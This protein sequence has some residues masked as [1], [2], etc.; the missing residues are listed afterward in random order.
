MP[1]VE[2]DICQ[3]TESVWEMMLGLPVVR[4][5]EAGPADARDDSITGCIQITGA[6]EVTVLMACSRELARKATARMFDKAAPDVEAEEIRDAVGKLTHMIGGGFKGLLPGLCFLS[7]PVVVEGN[8]YSIGLSGRGVASEV[9]FQCEGQPLRV[10]LLIPNEENAPDSVTQITEPVGAQAPTST[11]ILLVED[12]AMAARIIIRLLNRLGYEDLTEAG[13]GREALWYLERRRFDLVITDW[14]MPG[15]DGLELVQRIRA[16]ASGKKIPI[17]MLTAKGMEHDLLQ[18]IAA[19][20]DDYILKPVKVETL[21]A[22]IE[23]LIRPKTQAND[24][25]TP[26]VP[27]TRR[28]YDHD[29]LWES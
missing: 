11:R 12:D 17:L 4:Q 3:I 22:K 26:A 15:M 24:T 14:M 23:K 29:D 1:I 27:R 2:S 16:S 21:Q 10:R 28:R 9:V 5:D 25:K 20:V 8:D 18:A 13:N 6:W 7:L 19:G